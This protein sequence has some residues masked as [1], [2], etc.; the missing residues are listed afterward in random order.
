MKKYRVVMNI[1]TEPWQTD[2]LFETEDKQKAVDFARSMNDK[3][4]EIW[5]NETE[6]S[7][8]LIEY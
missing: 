6:S 7:Y 2:T 3:D 4:V 1:K 8:D 5:T